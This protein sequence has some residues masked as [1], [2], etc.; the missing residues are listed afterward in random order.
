MTFS[1]EHQAWY[2]GDGRWY[3][4][5]RDNGVWRVQWY[6]GPPVGDSF[7]NLAGRDFNHTYPTWQEA[8]EA[9]GQVAKNWYENA[10]EEGRASRP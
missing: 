4:A 8:N 3:K 5:A 2:A 6:D 9:A 7:T 10:S 1:E